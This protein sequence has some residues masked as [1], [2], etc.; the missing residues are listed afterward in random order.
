MS[1]R[2]TLHKSKKFNQQI[3]RET[4]G[5]GSHGPTI[6][7]ATQNLKNVVHSYLEQMHFIYTFRN[8]FVCKQERLTNWTVPK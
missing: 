8:S 3:K 4:I 6:N 1:Q 7:R 2:I 5:A